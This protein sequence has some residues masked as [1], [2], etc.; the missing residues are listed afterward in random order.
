M[1][2]VA[3]NAAALGAQVSVGGL[4]GADEQGMSLR[5]T[6]E[7]L[8]IN[9]SGLLT[10][11]QRPTTSK[12]R[13]VA[14]SQQVVRVDR[15]DGRPISPAQEQQLYDWCV[16]CLPA[17]DVCVI[18]DYAKGVLSYKLTS[19]IIGLAQT[20]GKPVI[21]DPK[22]WDYKRYLGASVVTPNLNE[23]RQAL[24]NDPRRTADLPSIGRGLIDLLP[25][26]SILV[27]CGPDGVALFRERHSPIY[28]PSSARQVYD[29]T[30]AGDTLIATLAVWMAVGC[31]L[32]AA[33][34]TANRAA[35]LAVGKIGTAT[36]SVNELFEADGPH[37]QQAHVHSMAAV[38]K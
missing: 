36:V 20:C 3:V 19:Q 34:A 13:I 26:S 33:A 38:V 24:G 5:R 35:G 32:E 28:I 10:D 22:G 18:S 1:A 6:L 4:V 31:S 27:T 30:G 8:G 12:T 16:T 37:F 23:A 9:T 7:S 25:G 14:H 15:E 29:V 11:C 2:N 17:M 21:V